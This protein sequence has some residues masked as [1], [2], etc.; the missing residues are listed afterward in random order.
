MLTPDPMP[1]IRIQVGKS[2]ILFLA[3]VT[4]FAGCTPAGP[5]ALF[6]GQS[7]LEQS[8][9][10][11]AVEK[12]RLATQL[13]G[14]NAQAYNYLGIACHHAGYTAEA[15][16]AY[17]RALALNPDL[18]EARFNLGSLWLEQNKLEQAKTEFTAYT[19]RR[20]NSVEGWLK[21]GSVQLRSSE[22]GPAFARANDLGAAERSFNTALGLNPHSAE[23]L[24][25]C[26][27]VK[28]RRGHAAEAA[29]LFQKSLAEQP[30]YGPAILN[31]AIVEQQYLN[32]RAAAVEKYHQY[33][34]LK[35]L[36]ENAEA[37]RILVGQL[38][39]E[40]VNAAHLPSLSSGGSPTNSVTLT[41]PE[42]VP[43][44]NPAVVKAPPTNELRLAA[45]QKSR[46]LTNLAPAAVPSGPKPAS[47]PVDLSVS[48]QTETLREAPVLKVAEGPP[49]PGPPTPSHLDSPQPSAK[50]SSPQGV[51][52]T[53][54]D[55][56]TATVATAAS[57]IQPPTAPA[58]GLSR[59]YA[60]RFPPKPAPGNRSEAERS[61]A[62]GV[63][64]QQSQHLNE[65]IQAYRQA[66][67]I[68]PSYFDA[69][70]N[71]GVAAAE[72]TNLGL[73]L[74][75]YESA[76]AARPDSLDARYNFAL[77]LKQANYYV[78]AEHELEQLLKRAPSDSRA[79][80]AL[81]NLYAQQLQNPANARLHYLKVLEN[82]PRNPQAGAI[83]YWLTDNPP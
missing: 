26:G 83:R 56:R 5:R 29:H 6:K 30:D 24:A 82:D 52:P 66:T 34:S 18:A 21:L 79:H 7:L 15:E 19:L 72:A 16:K 65:A 80:L 44:H 74:A 23:A 41:P 50:S 38:E 33:L 36:P 67:R 12:L 73:A 63:Q 14:T 2:F 11:E 32:D 9:Y 64:A 78:D 51:Y 76:L 60:Y 43:F 31:L 81:G 10:T 39:Q 13:L 4:F 27:L 49:N 71:L 62:Q 42:V 61:F 77:T 70:Y 45:S 58:P 69:Y 25:A 75:S 57:E 53:G 40:L 3:A 68:D 48:M 22:S 37:V 28:V 46:M 47:A 8:R 35:P 59:R 20:A 54:T 17:Q 55:S 1:T